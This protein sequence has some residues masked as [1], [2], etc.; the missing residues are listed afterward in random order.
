MIPYL[1]FLACRKNAGGKLIIKIA[2]A[3]QGVA[4][5]WFEI[6]TLLG[7]RVDKLNAIKEECDGSTEACLREVIKVIQ[8][9]D[10]NGEHVVTVVCT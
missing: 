3:L 7:I 2:T 5:K 1:K 8:G 6:A 9:C 4:S 10:V